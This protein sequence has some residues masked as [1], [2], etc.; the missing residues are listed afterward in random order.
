M[1]NSTKQ[2]IESLEAELHNAKALG[3]HIGNIVSLKLD[4]EAAKRMAQGEE[5]AG[6]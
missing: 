1:L 3:Y 4:I 6:L 5:L 2:L